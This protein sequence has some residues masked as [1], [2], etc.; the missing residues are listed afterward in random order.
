MLRYGLY[1][2]VCKLFSRY[3]TELRASPGRGRLEGAQYVGLVQP[4]DNRGLKIAEVS[5]R[6]SPVGEYPESIKLNL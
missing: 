5:F 2:E 1:T 3:C 4:A 6:N